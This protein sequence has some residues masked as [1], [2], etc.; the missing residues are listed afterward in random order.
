[1]S[2]HIDVGLEVF[3]GRA[4]AGCAIRPVATLLGLDFI[5]L[6]WERFDLLIVKERFF[7]PGIQLFL[8]MLHDQEFIS[9]AERF[10]GY[11]TRLSGKMVF[12]R[13]E[14]QPTP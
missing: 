9:L 8:G 10:E 11:D 1:M 14:G 2:R 5:P 13:S 3:A 4:D 12:P 6:R 7:D